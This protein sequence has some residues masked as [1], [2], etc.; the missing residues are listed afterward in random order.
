MQAP[1]TSK[2]THKSAGP[3]TVV[4]ILWCRRWLL[5]VRRDLHISSRG[6]GALAPKEPHFL[7]VSGPSLS[8]SLFNPRFVCVS[9]PRS[10]D[11]RS[12]IHRCVVMIYVHIMC[13]LFAYYFL[14]AYF[15][16]NPSSNPNPRSR[17]HI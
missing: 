3:S 17:D 11:R 8:W 4:R 15:N 10:C 16:P 1:E 12:Y 9:N 2:N 5:E 7:G 6:M 13:I 14:C